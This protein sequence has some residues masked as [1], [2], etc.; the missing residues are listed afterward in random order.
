M[1]KALR[2]REGTFPVLCR[3]LNIIFMIIRG[4]LKA[5]RAPSTSTLVTGNRRRTSRTAKIHG[6]FLLFIVSSVELSVA[7]SSGVGVSAQKRFQILISC[8][9][10]AD[11]GMSGP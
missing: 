8:L 6:N 11:P 7:G 2:T 10:D 4:V 5:E 3:K 1:P 9:A